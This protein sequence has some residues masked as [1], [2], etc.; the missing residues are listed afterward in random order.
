MLKK[1][2]RLE[3]SLYS[4]KVGLLQATFCVEARQK[5]LFQVHHSLANQI[6]PAKVVIIHHLDFQVLYLRDR[7]FELKHPT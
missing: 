5:P 7:R 2:Q 1:T 4:R 3:S 6:V